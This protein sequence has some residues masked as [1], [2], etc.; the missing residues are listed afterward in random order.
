MANG[1]P[2]KFDTIIYRLNTIDVSIKTIS[3][4]QDKYIIE[5]EKQELKIKSNAKE[6]DKHLTGHWKY[7]LLIFSIAGLISGIIAKWG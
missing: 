5:T 6:I 4:K 3:D 2:T 7:T 1:K